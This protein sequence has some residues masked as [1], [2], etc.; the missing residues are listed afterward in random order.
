VLESSLPEP[1]Y[2]GTM[3]LFPRMNLC[4]SRNEKQDIVQN[5]LSI[6]ANLSDTEGPLRKELP[7]PYPIYESPISKTTEGNSTIKSSKEF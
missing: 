6:L 4:L 2:K 5:L 7:I 1:E 3:G